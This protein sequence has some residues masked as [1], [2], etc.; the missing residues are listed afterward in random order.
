M[1]PSSQTWGDTN[2]TSVTL[3]TLWSISPPTPPTTTTT[4]TDLDLQSLTQRR[5]HLHKDNLLVPHR[6][7][8]GLLRGG[9]T[10]RGQ[11]ECKLAQP[12][13]GGS[14]YIYR[15][16]HF[17]YPN[18]S[19]HHSF[20][21]ADDHVRV[22]ER[23]VVSDEGLG[24]VGHDAGV[25]PGEAFCSVHLHVE[26]GPGSLRGE[27]FRDQQ[28]PDGETHLD[29]SETGIY[30]TKTRHFRV[31]FEIKRVSDLSI[32]SSASLVFCPGCMTSPFAETLMSHFT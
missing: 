14:F 25:V 1:L 5:K 28:V 22:H 6:V 24:D 20:E 19:T 7:C 23:R 30:Q 26:T 17:I 21:E 8:I 32:C 29:Q 9:S 31:V 16:L 10:L 3:N 27:T 18:N 13:A 11:N 4:A 15:C 12:N 2:Q